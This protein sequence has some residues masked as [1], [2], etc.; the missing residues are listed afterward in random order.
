[1]DGN[2]SLGTSQWLYDYVIWN[3]TT[4]TTA[5]LCSHSATAP[6]LPSGYTYFARVGACYLDSSGNLMRVLQKGNKARYQV[7]AATN[8]AALPTAASGA[9]SQWTAVSMT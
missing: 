1:Y 5:A 8:T 4:S 6:T 3:P 7:T 2:G 9:Q